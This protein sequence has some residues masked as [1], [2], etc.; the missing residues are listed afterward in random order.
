MRADEFAAH[1]TPHSQT[2]V[3]GHDVCLQILGRQEW[4]GRGA[5]GGVCTVAGARGSL[6]RTAVPDGTSVRTCDH[7]GGPAVQAGGAGRRQPNST[8]I[9]VVMRTSGEFVCFLLFGSPV[10]VL[11]LVVGTCTTGDCQGA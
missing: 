10:P 3:G 5:C 9:V 4:H 8:G 11:L 1:G 6:I 2:A 7:R